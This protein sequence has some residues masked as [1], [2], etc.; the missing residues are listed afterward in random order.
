MSLKQ[1][2]AFVVAVVDDQLWPNPV[3]PMVFFCVSRVCV[4]VQAFAAEKKQGHGSGRGDGS[5]K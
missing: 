3:C 4:C 5:G 2:H 1:W